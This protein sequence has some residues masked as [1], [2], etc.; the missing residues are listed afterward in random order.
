[1]HTTHIGACHC[2][3]VRF[4]VEASIDHVRVCDCSICSKRGALIFRVPKTSLRLLTSRENL[5]LYKW[6]TCTGEDFFCK[7]CG[8]LPFRK[9][10]SLTTEEIA[11]GMKPFDGWAVN[12]RCLEDFDY[13]SLPVVRIKG[14]KIALS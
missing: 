10:S 1:M 4:E 13:I 8:V 3:N 6:R 2:G 11:K 12:V 7:K 14:R 9:P 5:N